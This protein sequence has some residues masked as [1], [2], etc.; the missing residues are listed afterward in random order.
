MQDEIRERFKVLDNELAT[1]NRNIKQLTE[2]KHS[3]EQEITTNNDKIESLEHKAAHLHRQV[4]EHSFEL[5]SLKHEHATAVDLTVVQHT[6]LLHLRQSMGTVVNE[7][8]RLA[9]SEI[10]LK[11]KVEELEQRIILEAQRTQALVAKAAAG[12]AEIGLT[13]ASYEAEQ[14]K[15]ERKEKIA[16]MGTGGVPLTVSTIDG[17]TVEFKEEILVLTDAEYV[18]TNDFVLCSNY[19]ILQNASTCR[20]CNAGI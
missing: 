4:H 3:L 17:G 14:E 13:Q 2:I 15:I 16:N 11:E 12:A 19:C 10:K 5:S 18:S 8:N 6:E 20:R 9:E 7:R 1:A